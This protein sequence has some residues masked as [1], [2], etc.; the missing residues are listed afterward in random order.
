MFY[1]RESIRGI[2]KVG[3]ALDGVRSKVESN[4]SLKW[5]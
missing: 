4:G 5:V 2:S 3:P 1:C